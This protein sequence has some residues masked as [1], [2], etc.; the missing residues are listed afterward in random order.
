MLLFL[1][2]ILKPKNLNIKQSLHTAASLRR[3]QNWPNLWYLRINTILWKLSIY[4]VTATKYRAL[5]KNNVER[6]ID[7][8]Y[9]AMVDV[10]FGLQ[11]MYSRR[12]A[13]S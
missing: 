4:S 2:R 10:D 1:Q 11:L 6:G 9:S 3:S 5:S 8:R 7:R 13:W 12:L